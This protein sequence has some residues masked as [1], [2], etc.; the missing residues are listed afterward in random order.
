[1]FSILTTFKCTA[2]IMLLE[3]LRADAEQ[4]L[5]TA[6]YC[7]NASPQREKQRGAGLA[8]GKGIAGRAFTSG[9]VVTWTH[10]DPSFIT[11][12]TDYRKYYASG[13]TAP[14]K[15]GAHYL[16]IVNIDCLEENAFS[17]KLHAELGGAVADAISSITA[18]LE[19]R[20]TVPP[21]EAR[22][23]VKSIVDVDVT[24]VT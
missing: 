12:R 22:K 7:H 13:L 2:S 6:Q 8:V 4:I 14:I 19:L 18:A 20:M 9:D 16:G 17:D 5:C 21:S 24:D 15:L 1:M 23:E 3:P 10:T 11:T